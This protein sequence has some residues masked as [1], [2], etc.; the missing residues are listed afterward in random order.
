[1]RGNPTGVQDEIR[2]KG[3]ENGVGRM[4]AMLD[5][6]RNPA[7]KVGLPSILMS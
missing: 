4:A 1:M 5:R 7:K 6:K 3:M 2:R